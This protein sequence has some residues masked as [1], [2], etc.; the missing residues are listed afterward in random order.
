[1][2]SPPSIEEGIP[3]ASLTTLGVG[4][5]VRYLARCDDAA[6]L[7]EALR[8]ARSEDLATFI[9]GGGSNLLVADGG[10][11]GLVIQLR[12][13]TVQIEER[14]DRVR[15]R[16]GAGVE[17]DALVERVV[18]EGLGGL[19][20]L[21]GIPGLV[22][23]APMQ[24][25]G[26]YGQEVSET[27]RAVQV[28]ERSTG[29][30]KSL[31]AADCDFGYRTSVFKGAWRDRYVVTGV[32]FLLERRTEGAVRYPDLRRRLGVAEGR[33]APSLAEVRAAVLDVRRGKSMVLDDPRDPNRRSA[34]SFFTNPVVASELAEEVRRRTGRDMPAYPAD[35]GRVKLSAAWLIERAGFQRGEKRRR[36]GISSRHALALVNLGGAK[37]VELVALAAE[38]KGRVRRLFGVTLQPE[39]VFLGFDR[40]AG[41]LLDEINGND[42][43]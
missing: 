10:F 38:I 39:P 27:I 7:D 35:G 33:P 12:E 28:V 34:G 24:N 13:E 16:A 11:D 9:L 31:S 42:R 22:G 15:V 36:A 1:M 26:A 30:A 37:A 32:D 8:W 18:D 6:Q 40:N 41:D 3:F 29:E 20:C 43:T 5:P 17:W 23:A 19:E 2:S 4:G 21:S 14:G 25:I